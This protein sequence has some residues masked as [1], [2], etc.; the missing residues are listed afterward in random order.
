MG[1]IE[2]TSP[3]YTD[4]EESDVKTKL[5]LVVQRRIHPKLVGD[6][7]LTSPHAITHER[8]RENTVAV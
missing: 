5:L 4:S 6:V 8:Y 1:L 3:H 2:R 7:R